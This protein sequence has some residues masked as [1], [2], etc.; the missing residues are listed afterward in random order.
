MYSNS[1][2]NPPSFPSFV[3]IIV[4]RRKLANKKSGGSQGEVHT[5]RGSG[6]AAGAEED[7]N[8]ADKGGRKRRFGFPRRKKRSNDDDLVPMDVDGDGLGGPDGNP[9]GDEE[10]NADYGDQGNGVN[11]GVSN[12]VNPFAD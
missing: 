8:G 5:F 12:V 7:F 2:S 1:S 6:S 11:V 9:F 10:E 3:G 4:R